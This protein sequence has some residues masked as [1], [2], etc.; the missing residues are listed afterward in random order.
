M[1]GALPYT[2]AQRSRSLSIPNNSRMSTSSPAL[3]AMSLSSSSLASPRASEGHKRLSLGVSRDDGQRDGVGSSPPVRRLSLSLAGVP[4][5]ASAPQAGPHSTPRARLSYRVPLVS[6]SSP[7]VGAAKNTA[8]HERT[9]SGAGAVAAESSGK[10]NHSPLASVVA[11]RKRE[12]GLV[13]IL[14]EEADR[15]RRQQQR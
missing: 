4:A 10:A 9:E 11:R 7:A 1:Q 5:S 15:R 8:A 13:K 12:E 14:Q 6:P 2:V 3:T